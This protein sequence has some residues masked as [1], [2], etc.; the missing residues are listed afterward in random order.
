MNK[1]PEIDDKKI[2]INP[3]LGTLRIEVTKVVGGGTFVPVRDEDTNTTVMLPAESIMERQQNTKLYHCTGCK[4][5]I[6]NLSPGAKSLFLY[7]T[8]NLDAGKDYIWIN[9]EHYMN[10]NNVKSI[11]TVKT[12]IEELVRYVLIANSGVKGVY[13]INSRL[14]FSGNRITKYPNNVMVKNTWE[15]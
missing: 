14:Y 11:N 6:Y 7:I 8:Y 10:K 1:R 3:F 5:I 13:W 9:T 4:D 2:G 15:K 12:A